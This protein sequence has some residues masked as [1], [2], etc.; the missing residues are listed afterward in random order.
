MLN[1]V[2]NFLNK[3][4]MYRVVLYV[5]IFFFGASLV[6]SL[7]GFLP[8]SPTDLISSL[9]I[10]LL[11]S[12]ITNII[13]SFFYD[14]PTNT[15]SIY[16]TALILFFLI[17]PIQSGIYSQ[18]LPFA[19]WASV[20]AMASKYILAIKGKHIF[21]PAAFA[22]ALT[23][24]TINQSASWWIGTPNM[25]PFVLI[26]GF[27]IIRKI[28]R[29]DLFFAFLISAFTTI[30]VLAMF[31]GSD[32]MTT[33]MRTMTD[34]AFFFFAFVMLTEPLTAP[35]TK[36]LRIAFGALVG[37]LFAPALHFGIFYS[38]PELALVIGNIFAY[39][40]SPKEKLFL[41]LK[42]RI[43]VG[44]DT[45]D[46]IFEKDK[47][48]NFR[49]GQ[50]MEW[51]LKHRSPDTRG[52]RRY[53]TLASSPTEDEIHLG[54]KFYPEPSS[55]KNHLLAMPEGGGIIAAQKSGDFV[56]PE[57]SEKDLVFIAGGIGITPFRSMIKYLLDKKQK[58]TITLL[59]SNKTTKDI[60]YKEVFDRARAELGIKTVYVITG[61]GEAVFEESMQ[62]GSI[63]ARMIEKEI[64]NYLNKTFYISGPR[65]MVDAFENTLKSIGVSRKN[66]KTDFFPGFA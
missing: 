54:V 20:W 25:L 17:T 7:F 56:L 24:L 28:R 23:A 38:T 51:T 9:L 19:F 35:T 50:Y 53:F 1:F 27:L 13:F 26:G 16:I 36:W 34:S 62:K 14:A 30:S 2:D 64:P 40:V 58:R 6:L 61:K 29:A 32:I 65:G 60:A 22:V 11:I 43:K 41:K 4:T 37:F 55:F 63:D 59:Y 8:Y 46:F 47:N 49:P 10:I 3:T 18:F 5:L 44:V 31:R 39:I 66:I 45:Y 42:D 57:D 52:N 48:F 33:L 21:N 15:E 12:W